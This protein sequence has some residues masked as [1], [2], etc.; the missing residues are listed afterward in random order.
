[1][2]R[3]AETPQ[4]ELDKEVVGQSLKDFEDAMQQPIALSD[5]KL[6]CDIAGFGTG[7]AVQAAMGVT[8]TMRKVVKAF[9]ML[10]IIVL[11]TCF[12]D[13]SLNTVEIATSFA[14]VLT[15]FPTSEEMQNFLGLEEEAYPSDGLAK[16]CFWGEW[17]SYQHKKNLVFK[18]KR[19]IL[20]SHSFLLCFVLAK[21]SQVLGSYCKVGASPNQRVPR[22][23]RIHPHWEESVHDSGKAILCTWQSRW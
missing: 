12:P 18:Y 6:G 4:E 8:Q 21:H 15:Q 22:C 3:H 5:P 16:S 2:L 11:P 10:G 20:R 19:K 23:R 7:A 9:D 17:V 13:R 1:M 14:D